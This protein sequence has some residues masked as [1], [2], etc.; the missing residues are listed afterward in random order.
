MGAVGIVAV[1]H[2]LRLAEAAQELAAQMVPGAG[3]PIALAAGAGTEA[4]GSP[5]LGTDATR[6][7]EA[8]DELAGTCDGVLVLMDLGSA[9]MSAEFALELRASVVP[10]RLASAPF[11]EGLLAAAVTAAQGASLDAVAAE[12]NGALVAKSA[13]LEDEQQPPAAAPMPAAPRADGEVVRTVVVRNPAG[14]HA[15]P[16]AMIGQAAQG[17]PL[18]LRLLPAGEPVPA[19]SMMRLLAFGARRGDEVE[20]EGERGAVE[21]VA[22]LFDD[23]FGEM[24]GAPSTTEAPSTTGAPSTTDE[25]SG[26]PA[27]AQSPAAD[28][29]PGATLHGLG[30]SP[31]VA[32]APVAQLGEAIAEPAAADEVPE[33]RREAEAARLAPAVAEVVAALRADAA[34]SEGETAQ[35][36]EATALLAAD[37]DFAAGAAARVRAEGVSA[38]RAVWDEAEA[39]ARLLRDLGGRMAERVADVRSVRDR[40]VARLTGA[41]VPGIPDR[42]E[43]FVLV[44]RDLAPAETAALGRSRCV[45]LVTEEGGPTSHTAILARALG[46]PAVV[47]A[48]GATAIPAETVV[49]V[50]GE[51]GTVQLDPPERQRAATSEDPPEFDGRG[52]LADGTPV[53]LRANVGG[54]VDAHAAAAARAQGIGLF[55]T[56]FCFLDRAA[57]PTVPEQV[58]A[59]RGVLAPFAG[60][61][62]VVRTLDA[63][64]DKPLPFATGADEENPALGVRGLRVAR[65]HP[66]LLSH[67]LTAIADAAAQEG[68]EVEVMAPMVATVDEARDFVAACRAAGIARAGIMIET[69]AAALLSAEMLA[70]VDFVSLGTNDL[71]QYTM[72]ADRLSAP[73]GALNDPWQPAVL[74]LIGTVGAAGRA[75]GKPV[76]VCGE[77]GGD[78]AIAPVL[79]G[80]GVTSLSMTARSLARVAA[81]LRTV[82]AD[83]CR[84]AAE[85]AL[86]APTAVEA[87][88]AAAAVLG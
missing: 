77:A 53:T 7:A 82:T 6:V 20:L 29:V 70:V 44:A 45:A 88:A 37:P 65:T 62:V 41:D 30:V 46:I 43:P 38:A 73:L 51:S 81:R 66:A 27:A 12:A 3:V 36:L 74:R 68:A 61:T 63:G 39:Q 52:Q 4:D 85:A 21:R 35:I 86:G 18:R 59:Y 50:D 22:A 83:E 84:R 5:I 56:E 33:D 9:V 15:R 64:S 58:A 8:I 42:A 49:L 87:R 48:A 23:G 13:Q 76:G 17:A 75:R 28:L 67:Q 25:R 31:G 24:D 57:E 1:S 69:P 72:A 16:A 54:A 19:A 78:P 14:V 10:V 40:L 26:A 79:V 47:G 80:L 34:R 32:V 2:S 60:R 55:R 11:V 71:T